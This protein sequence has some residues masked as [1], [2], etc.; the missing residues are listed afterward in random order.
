[1]L[2][3]H[4][5]F[6]HHF[7]FSSFLFCFVYFGN[8]HSL[9]TT[10][11]LSGSVFSVPQFIRQPFIS[12]MAHIVLICAYKI[13]YRIPFGAVYLNRIFCFV[14]LYLS[15]WYKL[16]SFFCHLPNN[17]T[18]TI[19]KCMVFRMFDL[20]C[21]CHLLEP[22]YF[23]V[24]KLFF[25]RSVCACVHLL[26]FCF[27]CM[28]FCTFSRPHFH[29]EFHFISMSTVIASLHFLQ[30]RCEH[31]RAFFHIVFFLPFVLCASI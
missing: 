20:F 7:L 29:F 24:L 5:L 18:D 11:I 31:S 4:T 16:S 25:Y 9:H 26:L 23:I 2:F 13:I 27:V 6:S 17:K 19:R 14:H 21:I 3:Y 12:E 28:H 8:K 22:I 30:Q 10:V 15:V 1:M